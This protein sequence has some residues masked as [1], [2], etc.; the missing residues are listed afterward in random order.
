[1]RRR[2]I[3]LGSLPSCLWTSPGRGPRLLAL[4]GFT[5]SGADFDPLAR[6]LDRPLWA[7]DLPGHG[8]AGC[9]P[10][11]GCRLPTVARSLGRLADRSRLSILLGYSLGA[12]HALALA[13]ARPRRFDALILV[14]A[15]PGLE[16]PSARAARAS[17]DESWARRA[18]HRDVE[19]FT[20]AWSLLPI[21]ASQE[22]IEPAAHAAM[23]ARRRRNRPR[24]LAASLR[25]AGTGSMA[26]LWDALPTLRMP[27]LLVVGAEDARYGDLAARMQRSLPD[28]RTA[29]IADAGH[30]AHLEQPEA[31]AGVIEG[32]LGERLAG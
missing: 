18:E 11:S 22:R 6:A 24:G 2:A 13:A 32:F 23:L 7:P 16:D 10:P 26:P 21:I 27:T 30:C 12:R 19:T 9:P 3:Q 17:W 1:M 15:S 4:H 25:G 5:G 20:G 28:A 14:G 31:T 8:R 29:I